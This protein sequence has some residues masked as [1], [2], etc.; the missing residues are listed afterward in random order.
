MLDLNDKLIPYSIY[1]NII[2]IHYLR[3]EI[4]VAFQ[5][6]LDQI[7]ILYEIDVCR[8]SDYSIYCTALFYVEL[9][10]NSKQRVSR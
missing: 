5:Q 6:H 10:I 4:A 2:I 9:N 8:S 1:L 3:E 7:I